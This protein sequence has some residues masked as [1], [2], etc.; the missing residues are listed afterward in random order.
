MSEIKRT[1]IAIIYV[2]TMT[3]GFIIGAGGVYMSYVG[4]DCL[5]QG[6]LDLGRPLV[7]SGSLFTAFGFILF[8]LAFLTHWRWWKRQRKET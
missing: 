2:A 5:V 4:R 1:I 3:A 6:A 8:L 7:N